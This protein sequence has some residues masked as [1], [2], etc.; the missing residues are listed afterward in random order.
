M[1]QLRVR[2][3][4][5]RLRIH[6]S[7]RLRLLTGMKRLL[8][9]GYLLLGQV[10]MQYIGMS[11]I[12]EQQVFVR[13]RI[14]K[15]VAN[16][17]RQRRHRRHCGDQRCHQR[18]RTLWPRMCLFN[19]HPSR[20][21]LSSRDVSH[22]L[23]HSRP[24]LYPTHRKSERCA[25]HQSHIG[26]FRIWARRWGQ[27]LHRE[28]ELGVY[29]CIYATSQKLCIRYDQYSGYY[30]GYWYPLADRPSH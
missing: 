6:R 30:C 3:A 16:S 8:T 20:G 15:T 18:R 28:S 7:S 10:D 23:L 26:I 5:V 21:L 19:N 29:K 17:P 22:I 13:S 4:P 24:I 9:K 25:S 1:R 14:C 2:R 12:M 11:R 27:I